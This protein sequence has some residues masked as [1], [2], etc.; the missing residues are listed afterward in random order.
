MIESE[1]ENNKNLSFTQSNISNIMRFRDI[2][3]NS[4]IY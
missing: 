2:D 4:G 1:K 3:F